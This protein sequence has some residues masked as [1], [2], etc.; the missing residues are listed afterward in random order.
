MIDD[1]IAA[2]STPIGEGGI[3]IIRVSGSK[4]LT[5][6]DQMFIART[7]KPSA[8]ATHTIHLGKIV[9]A[10]QIVDHAMLSVM[11][12]PGSYT[13]EDTVEFNCH[14]GMFVART[15]LSLCLEHGARLAEPGEFTKRAFLNGR[16][17]L[18]QAEAVM[19]LISAKTDRAQ[20]A[21]TNALEGHLSRQVE[22]IRVRLITIL[23][24]IEAQ[25]DFP[26]DD[27]PTATRDTLLR[28]TRDICSE[29]DKLLSTGREGKIL[30]QGVSISII[31]RPNVGKSSL[32]NLLLGEERSIVTSKPGTTRDTIEEF[33][34]VRGI[35][36]R[37]T[38]TAGIRSARGVVEAIGINRTRKAIQESDLTI[39]V[40]D[41]SR[42]LSEADED[43]ISRYKDKIEIVVINKVDTL[44]RLKLSDIFNNVTV[45]KVSCVTGFGREQLKD[46]IEY[47]VWRGLKHQDSTDFT[48]NERHLEAITRA[49]ASLQEG[50]N[51][52]ESRDTLDVVAQF[53]RIGLSAIGEVVG[54]TSTEDLL[55]SIFSNFCIGK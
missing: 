37:V 4:A 53:Y 28:E 16:L 52:I 3:A 12:A 43:F 7:G 18:A 36:I 22:T 35:P 51:K 34:N 33:V 23:A 21:A 25:L 10:G 32:M 39:L 41:N 14:G 17:D 50:I 29:L 26:E 19:D 55:S 31:G 44:S 13:T 8:F 38:D 27:L 15:V 45:V 1:T 40:V 42:R 46:A 47:A 6:A 11:R 30:R 2:I 48:I 9:R 49:V 24:H 5:I 54:K 20:L